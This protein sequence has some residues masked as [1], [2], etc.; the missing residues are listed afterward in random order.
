MV[1]PRAVRVRGRARRLRSSTVEQPSRTRQMSVRSG[2][3]APWQGG[4]VGKAPGCYPGGVV[5]PSQVRVL[6]LPPSRCSS[7]GQSRG[8]LRPRLQV[9]VLPAVQH[10]ALTLAVVAQSDRAATA[11]EN[12]DHPVTRVEPALPTTSA[13]TVRRLRAGMHRRATCSAAAWTT[14]ASAAACPFDEIQA[15]TILNQ[16]SVGAGLWQGYCTHGEG[17]SP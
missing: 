12:P 2:P 11:A 8:L 17:R 1:R 5:R 4:R 15:K 9:R 7:T 14:P 6:P 3:E 13:I 10:P 16:V